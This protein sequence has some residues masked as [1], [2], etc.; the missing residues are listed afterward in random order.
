MVQLVIEGVD[1]SAFV[2]DVIAVIK[3]SGKSGADAMPTAERRIDAQAD[4]LDTPL[5]DVHRSAVLRIA[6]RQ[7]ALA[8][9]EPYVPLPDLLPEP[10]GASRCALTVELGG[11]GAPA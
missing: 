10:P 8:E 2:D 3:A 5:S 7:A 9:P 11:A 1:L 4:T 6:L